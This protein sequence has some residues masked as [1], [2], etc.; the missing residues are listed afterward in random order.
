MKIKQIWIMGSASD[1]WYSKEL[2]M[3]A[4]NLWKEIAKNNYILVYG[5]EKDSDSLS[6]VAWRWANSNWWKVVWIT[7]WNTPDIWWNMSK[8]TD[9]II[10][11]WMQR[12]G[13]REFVLVSS[14]DAI[15]VLWGWSWTLNEITIAYQKKIPIVVIEWTGGWADKLKNQYLDERWKNDPDRFI[16]K[17]VK[18]IKE[19][20]DYINNLKCN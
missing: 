13:G 15:I 4:F 19:A 11:T 1:L 8:Y 17:W 2:E 12:W 5:A 7:Y 3:L 14:C 10:N 6:S 9:V 16:C 20:V 18:G